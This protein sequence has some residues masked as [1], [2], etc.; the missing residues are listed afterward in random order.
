MSRVHILPD[1]WIER[2]ERLV[3][4]QDTRP[5]DQRLGDRE[6]LLHAA[7]HLRGYRS[8]AVAEAHC[9]QHRLGLLAGSGGRRRTAGR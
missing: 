4:Q 6:A 8:S 9:D 7:R 5:L 2:A 3:E 1:A